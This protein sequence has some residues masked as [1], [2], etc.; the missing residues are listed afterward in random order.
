MSETQELAVTPNYEI[1]LRGDYYW[2]RVS[3][4]DARWNRVGATEWEQ[5]VPAATDADR[6]AVADLWSEITAQFAV[7]REG[8][9]RRTVPE[10][11][12]RAGDRFETL[13][14]GKVKPE[15]AR[16]LTFSETPLGAVEQFRQGWALYREAQPGATLL[17][18]VPLELILT[19]SGWIV[20][21]RV[22][23]AE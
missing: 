6:R 9:D 17:V 15:G 19:T 14:G 12:P 4:H 22:L 13:A 2:R 23:I 18:R 3:Y 8:F 20:Y 16:G 1:D 10:G 11:S 21:C 7:I 5:W